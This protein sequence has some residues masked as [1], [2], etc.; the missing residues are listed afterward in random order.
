MASSAPMAGL[1]AKETAE[2]AN[3]AAFTDACP[4]FAGRPLVSVQRGGDPPDFLCL[5]GAGA[6]IGVEL[7][8]WINEQQTGPSKELHKLEKSYRTVIRST[9]VQPPKNIGMVFIYAKDRTS[10]APADATLFQNELYRFVADVDAAW[11]AN[12]DWNDRQG[13]DFKDFNGYPS[14][15]S[16]LEGLCFY[17]RGVAQYR[18]WF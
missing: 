8:Q 5:D 18:A 1:T 14:L 11:L 16:H 12:P 15:A 6:R 4:N 10:L 9:H 3:F 13:Y 17:S 7:V 2:A